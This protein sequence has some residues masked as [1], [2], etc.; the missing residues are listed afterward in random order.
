V[1]RPLRGRVD[2]ARVERRVAE[3]LRAPVLETLEVES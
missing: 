3:A 1:M 2:A